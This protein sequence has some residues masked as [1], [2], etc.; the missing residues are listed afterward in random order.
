MEGKRTEKLKYYSKEHSCT[1]CGRSFPFKSRLVIHERIHTGEKHINVISVKSP[2]F[3]I[4]T[5]LSIRGNI[6]EKS[7]MNVIFYKDIHSK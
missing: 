7:H 1:T 2:L 4:V 5:Y 6:Q 3:K